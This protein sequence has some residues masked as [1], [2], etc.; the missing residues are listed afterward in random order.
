MKEMGLQTSIL[1]SPFSSL[2]DLDPSIAQFLRG[3][4]AFCFHFCLLPSVSL[5]LDVTVFGLAINFFASRPS[6]PSSCRPPPVTLQ[7]DVKLAL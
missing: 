1:P 6:I 4:T 3:E 7:V 5:E 2:T